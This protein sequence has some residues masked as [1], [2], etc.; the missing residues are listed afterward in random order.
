MLKEN[1]NQQIKIKLLHIFHKTNIL[2]N[3]KLIYI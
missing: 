2:T 3:N 1:E